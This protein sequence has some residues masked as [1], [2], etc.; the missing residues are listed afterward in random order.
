MDAMLGLNQSSSMAGASNTSVASQSNALKQQ[1]FLK[2]MVSQVKNQ[3]PL[4]PDGA[5]DFL[6]QMAQFSTN[7]SINQMQAS[8]EQLVSSLQSNQALQASALVGRKVMVNSDAMNLGAEGGVNASFNM[9][10]GLT[11]LSASIF[12]PSGELIKTIPIGI[13]PEGPYQFTWDGTDANG[14]RLAAGAY[15]IKVNASYQNQMGTL[16]TMTQA[17]VDSVSLGQNGS[18]LKLNLAGVGTV[19]LSDVQQISM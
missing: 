6:S 19:S 2:L 1:D 14:Q 4:N 16:P 18:G 17:N 12:S 3:D 15:K 9:V 11:D 8:I 13:P 5:G 7:D 10:N